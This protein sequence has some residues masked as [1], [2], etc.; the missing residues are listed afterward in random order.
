[1]SALE[2]LQGERRERSPEQPS[3]LFVVAT[4]AAVA[5]AAVAFW[6]LSLIAA[7]SSAGGRLNAATLRIAAMETAMA[8]S[9]A[10]SPY[11]AGAV[12]PSKTE[13]DRLVQRRVGEAAAAAGISLT[14]VTV[15]QGSGNEA[16]GLTP[17]SISF[18]ARAQYDV[19]LKFLGA[20]GESQ[21]EIFVDTAD[22]TPDTSV[23][24]LQ[25]SGRALCWTVARQ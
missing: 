11:P 3:S 7:P 12:C 22:I 4:G 2:L 18:S 20:L 10:V 14:D 19:L 8:S 6:G 17:I 1:M 16:S 13:G 21:P 24:S 25:F 15:A 9:G 23:A 5:V